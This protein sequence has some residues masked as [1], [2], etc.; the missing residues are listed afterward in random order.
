[1][2][3]AKDKSKVEKE[4]MKKLEVLDYEEHKINEEVTKMKNRL[5]EITKEKANL[6]KK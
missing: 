1:M 6:I 5:A 2:K 4:R 3:A